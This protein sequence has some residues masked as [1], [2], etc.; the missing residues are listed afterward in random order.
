MKTIFTLRKVPIIPSKMPIFQKGNLDF[1]IYIHLFYKDLHS[2]FS[3]P[4][5]GLASK[6][7]GGG[8]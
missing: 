2:P 5:P 7:G 4:A 8:S 1:L 3:S 6:Y